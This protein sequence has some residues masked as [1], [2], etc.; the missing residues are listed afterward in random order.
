M[1]VLNLAVTIAALGVE[2]LIG[3]E[4]E[5]EAIGSEEAMVARW[6]VAGG[7][8]LSFVVVTAQGSSWRGEADGSG[9]PSSVW[10]SIAG[11]ACRRHRR[12]T[13]G[14]SEGG[15]T[16]GSQRGR[17]DPRLPAT[18]YTPERR[19][20][21]RGERQSRRRREK[22]ERERGVE[23]EGILVQYMQNTYISVAPLRLQIYS[24]GIVINM[25]IVMAY[26]KTGIF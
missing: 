13:A 17:P 2:V 18:A 16:R 8:R 22:R 9:M 11:H 10:S 14:S 19:A 12:T 21:R 25:Q 7:V 5:E 23:D 3:D 1:A 26:F 20:Q 6:V 4:M 15:R 24:S